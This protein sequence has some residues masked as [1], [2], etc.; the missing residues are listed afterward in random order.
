VRDGPALGTRL[1]AADIKLGSSTSTSARANLDLLRFAGSVLDE[2]TASATV[3][4]ILDTL[5]D[6]AAFIARTSPA[7]EVSSRLLDTLAAVLDSAPI[8]CHAIVADHVLGL[9]P[10]KDQAWA[11]SLAGVVRQIDASSWTAVRAARAR[12][13]ARDDHEALN[14]PLLG[15]AA[16]FYEDIRQE[17]TADILSGSA[18]ALHA[19]GDVRDLN[20]RV[21]SELISSLGAGL[22]EIISSAH[23]GLT[24]V[25]AQTLAIRSLCLI[26]GTPTKP[27]GRRCSN[28]WPIPLSRG[29]TKSVQFSASLS[30]LTKSQQANMASLLLSPLN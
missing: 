24:W 26:F 6:S 14:Y 10:I 30:K 20:P 23:K 8:P 18:D 29:R 27:N 3:Q 25:A 5:T 13:R 16:V 4:W 9:P 7:F 1:A 22:R 17:L 2:D 11:T 21:A 19:F 12:E 28:C 15:I